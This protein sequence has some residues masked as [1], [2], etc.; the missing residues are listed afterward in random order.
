MDR[1]GILV[2]VDGSPE[3]QTA[4]RWAAD[5]AR[6]HGVAITLMAAVPPAVV[7]WPMAALQETVAEC[8]RQTVEDI[9]HYA[10]ETVLASAGDPARAPEIRAEICWAAPLPALIEASTDARMVVVGSRGR[11]ALGRALLGSVSAGLLHHAHCPVTVVHSNFGRLPDP[12]A[13]VVLGVDGS[14]VSESATAVAFEEAARRGVDLVA[15]HTWTDVGALPFQ[16]EQWQAH[17]QA[18]AEVL[19]ERLAGWQE[20]YPDV[21]IRRRLEYE[22]PAHWLIVES[23]AAQL[24]VVGSHGRGGLT[25]MLLGSVSSAVVQSVDVPVTVVRPAR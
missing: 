11:G 9:L 15:V 5:T 25:G 6:L 16:S 4:V 22:A 12:A 24:V 2:G 18:A 3:S 13:P 21:R 17:E 23:Q 1:H 10:R 19:C 7:T 8:E 20:R 14:P